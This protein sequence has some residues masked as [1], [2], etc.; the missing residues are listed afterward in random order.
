[1]KRI[2]VVWLQLGELE[3]YNQSIVRFRALVQFEKKKEEK[4]EGVGGR[5]GNNTDQRDQRTSEA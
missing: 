1:M 2:P 3:V 5:E 4:K